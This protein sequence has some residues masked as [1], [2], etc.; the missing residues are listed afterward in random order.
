MKLMVIRDTRGSPPV[1]VRARPSVSFVHDVAEAFIQGG[2][3]T[4]LHHALRR[5]FGTAQYRCYALNFAGHEFCRITFSS[6]R[7]PQTVQY[8]GGIIGFA[9]KDVAML[10]LL[11]T[12]S[13]VVS[14]AAPPT[15]SVHPFHV[16]ESS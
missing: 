3:P 16:G 9:P 4:I 1:I 11:V 8:R 14:T 5:T 7:E 6:S 12:E 2:R 10:E 15:R 13:P